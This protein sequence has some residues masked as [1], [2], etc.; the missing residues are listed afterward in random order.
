MIFDDLDFY[1][2]PENKDS[3]FIYFVAE[4]NKKYDQII[5]DDRDTYR[6]QNGNY[7]GSYNPER[8]FVTLVLAFLDEYGIESNIHDISDLADQEFFAQFGQFKS[9]VEYLTTRFKLRQS[10][11]QSGGIGTFISIGS[12]YKSEIRKLL[13]T[14]RKIVNQEIQ[15]IN[16]RGRIIKKIEFLQSEVDRDQTTIDALFGRMVDLTQAIGDSAEN[17]DP[18]L[19][20]IERI[21]KI[22]WSK[23]KKVEQLPNPDRPKRI[24]HDEPSE[25]ESNLDD[26]IPF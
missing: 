5:R 1:D 4:I 11:I 15:D 16:K 14:A 6:D 7:E 8:S 3:A 21:K 26:E 19:D 23:S 17:L 22:F 2:L 13:D 18:L 20:K 9:K 25:S 12:D 24:T 10:R